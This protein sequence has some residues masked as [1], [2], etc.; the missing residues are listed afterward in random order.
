MNALKQLITDAVD[1]A[2]ACRQAGLRKRELKT[3]FT[4]TVKTAIICNQEGG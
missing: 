1:T 3:V 4:V 2:V